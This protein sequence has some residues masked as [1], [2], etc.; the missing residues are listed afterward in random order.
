MLQ[1]GNL[2]VSVSVLVAVGI[3]VV[4]IV[5]ALVAVSASRANGRRI[6]R[7]MG[8]SSVDD[9]EHR[10]GGIWE[11]AAKW[12]ELGSRVDG[13]EWLGRHALSRTG[14]VRYNPFEDTGADLSFSLALL[15]DERDGLVVTSLWGRDE[16]RVYA[17]PVAGGNSRYPLSSEEKQALDLALNQR[18]P[19]RPSDRRATKV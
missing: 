11:E 17:K 2:T 19:E 18:T 10:L 4:S 6:A 13:L 16:V 12:R 14:L 15:S 9:L 5:V 1:I 3:S 7:F 8:S